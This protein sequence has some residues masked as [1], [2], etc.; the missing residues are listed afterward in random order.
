MSES[1][2]QSADVATSGKDEW[3]TPPGIIR[4][5]Q[6]FDL[7]PCAPVNPP[8]H[9]ADKTFTCFDNGLI[10]EWAGFVWCN[11]P[12]SDAGKWLARMASHEGGGHR[13]GLRPHRNRSVLSARLVESNGALFHQRPAQFPSCHRQNR[14]RIRARSQRADCLRRNS[15]HQNAGS[16]TSAPARQV[17]PAMKTKTNNEPRHLVSYE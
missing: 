5:L 17:Y 8:W 7:D 15:S 13:A 14:Q 2:F 12:Y 11:P 6:P 1:L 16:D 3:L 10:K 4:A 9:L